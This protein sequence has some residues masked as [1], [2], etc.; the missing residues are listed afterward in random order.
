MGVVYDELRALAAQSLRRERREHTLEPTALVHEVYLQLAKLP[1]GQ[2][3]GK[4]QFFAA[5][6]TMIRRI[7]VDHARRRSRYKRGGGASRVTLGGEETE[8]LVGGPDIDLLALEEAVREL[9]RRSPIQEKIVELRY[10]GGLSMTEIAETLDV[11][12]RTVHRQWRVARAWLRNQL[13][14]DDD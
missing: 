7:L 6:A 11:D 13:E 12:R 5:A 4:H 3:H 14:G 9:S 2:W 10:F 1:S 8:A